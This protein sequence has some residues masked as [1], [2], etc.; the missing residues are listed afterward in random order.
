MMLQRNRTPEKPFSEVRIWRLV[1]A[2]PPL[3]PE[4]N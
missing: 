1:T 4:G 2:N 3:F